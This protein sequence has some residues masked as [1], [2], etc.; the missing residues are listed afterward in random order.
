[1]A[2][3]T[4]HKFKERREGEERKRAQNKPLNITGLTPKLPSITSPTYPVSSLNSR[5]AHASGVSPGSI[6]PAGIS[7]TTAS[8]GARH[9][10]CSTMR[11]VSLGLSGKERMAATPIASMELFLGRVRREADSQRRSCPEGSR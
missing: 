1:L 8:A 6:S 5:S 7:I 9:C 4:S 2:S 10:F 11:G 3:I